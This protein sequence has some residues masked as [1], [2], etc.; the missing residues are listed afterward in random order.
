MEKWWRQREMM[1]RKHRGCG[2]RER[3]DKRKKVTLKESEKVKWV[4]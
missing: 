2:V 3:A 4:I 1:L